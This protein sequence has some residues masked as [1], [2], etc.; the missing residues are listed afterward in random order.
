MPSDK[1]S[2]INKRRKLDCFSL[3]LMFINAFTLTGNYSLQKA[4]I[5][6]LYDWKSVIYYVPAAAAKQSLSVKEFNS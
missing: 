3:P 5:F 6:M 1:H 2:L 4:Q